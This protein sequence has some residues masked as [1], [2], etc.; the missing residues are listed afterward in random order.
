MSRCRAAQHTL[1]AGHPGIDA[2]LSRRAPSSQEAPF[3]TRPGPSVGSEQSLVYKERFSA[4]QSFMFSGKNLSHTRQGQPERNETGEASGKLAANL[5]QLFGTEQA[6]EDEQIF[7]IILHTDGMQFLLDAPHRRY[8]R[9][10]NQPSAHQQCRQQLIRCEEFK[11]QEDFPQA[12]IDVHAAQQALNTHRYFQLLLT[13]QLTLYQHRTQRTLNM[14]RRNHR[15]EHL[16]LLIGN[17]LVPDGSHAHVARWPTRLWRWRF[18]AHA[19]R[20]R[21]ALAPLV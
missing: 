11:E 17:V 5:A 2:L 14:P 3:A 18:I 8:L 4:P 15:R 7:Q 12:I 1:S 6:E 21:G 10:R 13:N 20:V 16:V 9:G 19:T